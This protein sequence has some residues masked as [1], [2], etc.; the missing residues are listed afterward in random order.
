MTAQNTDVIRSGQVVKEGH[1]GQYELDKHSLITYCKNK[2]FQAT[3]QALQN[4][5]ITR[6][7]SQTQD[8]SSHESQGA[9]TFKES[10]RRIT[11]KDHRV[12]HTHL[13]SRCH[14]R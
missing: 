8:H 5:Q 11:A 10:K 14:F 9:Y 2:E 7:Y 12:A 1:K 3:K 13:T 4:R 6:K